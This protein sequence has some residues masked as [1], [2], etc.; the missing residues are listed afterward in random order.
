MKI[1]RAS[2]QTWALGDLYVRWFGPNRIHG[3]HC[4]KCNTEST[5]RRRDDDPILRKHHIRQVLERQPWPESASQKTI[6]SVSHLTPK[7]NHNP[8][9]T[10]KKDIS[11]SPP[12]KP[13]RQ[14]HCCWPWRCRKRARLA[15]GCC[16]CT[17]SWESVPSCWRWS[18]CRIPW[19][20]SWWNRPTLQAFLTERR[21]FW[22]APFIQRRHP[23][24]NSFRKP[25]SRKKIHNHWSACDPG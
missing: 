7:L 22:H 2:C 11:P 18:I 3:I 16:T 13:D 15:L 19:T 20:Q 25:H 17:V 14:S 24:Q 4:I 10:C 12:W 8:I 6:P 23:V 5:I 1:Y 9:S 21:A